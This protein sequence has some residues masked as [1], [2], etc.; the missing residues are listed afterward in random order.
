M[1]EANATS[2]A[3]F[4]AIRN[5]L[6]A[7]S[8][9]LPLGAGADG[10]DVDYGAGLS[11]LGAPTYNLADTSNPT[12]EAD[13]LP[14]SCAGS[15]Y[16]VGQANLGN[17]T[18]NGS[19]LTPFTS[20]AAAL[21]ATSPIPECIIVMPGEYVTPIFIENSYTEPLLVTGY[22]DVSRLNTKDVI[23]W[24]RGLYYN[25]GDPSEYFYPDNPAT[26][27]NEGVAYRRRAGLYFGDTSANVEFSGFTFVAARFFTDSEGINNTSSPQAVVMDGSTN[28]AVSN[29]QFG[30]I[31]INNVEYPGWNNINATPILIVN[32]AEGARIESNKF[33]DNSTNSLNFF[34]TLAVINS[35]AVDNPV[36]IIGNDISGNSATNQGQNEWSA[37]L[38]SEGSH[39]D[40]INN[41]IHDNTGETIIRIKSTNP[42]DDPLS[43][44]I[45][46]THTHRARIVGNVFLNN[47]TITGSAQKVAGALINGHYSPMIYIINNTMVNNTIPTASPFGQ[48]FSRGD[49]NSATP[50]G[51]IQPSVANGW[52]FWEIHNNLIYNNTYRLLV[53]DTF[54]GIASPSCDRIPNDVSSGSLL[55]AFNWNHTQG[56]NQANDP[57]GTFRNR[58]AQNNW[59]VSNQGTF[60]I[61]SGGEFGACSDAI[62]TNKNSPANPA[63]NNQNIVQADNQ[64]VDIWS[65]DDSLL[66][67][68]GDFQGILTQSEID[69]PLFVPSH[70][71]ADW[72]YYALADTLIDANNGLLNEYSDGI[73]AARSKWLTDTGGGDAGDLYMDNADVEVDIFATKRDLDVN[74]WEINWS[75]YGYDPLIAPPRGVSDTVNTA[76]YTLDIGA[77]EFSPLQFEIN[78]VGE[79]DYYDTDDVITVETIEYPAQT[80]G[81]LEDSG[82]VTFNFK[83][84]VTG[85][86]GKL[87]FTIFEHPANYGVQ[88]DDKF[89][90]TKG[91]VNQGIGFNEYF[92]YCPPR[93]FYTSTSNSSPDF[94]S[95]KIKVTDEAGA[96]A[97]GE[98]RFTIDPVDDPNLPSTPVIGDD[99]PS[100]TSFEVVT[101]LG[102]NPSVR[103]RPYTR[104]DNFFFSENDNSDFKSGAQL[105]VDYPFTYTI[106]D[107]D[108]L[109]DEILEGTYDDGFTGSLGGNPVI[110]L[111]LSESNTG[112]ATITYNITDARGNTSTGNKLIVRSVSIIPAEGLHDDTS[113]VWNYSDAANAKFYTERADHNS[114]NVPASG[115][116]KAL[117][118]VGA[119][120]NT[121]HTTETVGDT[122]TFR[123][124]GTGFTAFMRGVSGSTGTFALNIYD[125]DDIQLG[126]THLWSAL[127]GSDVVNEVAGVDTLECTTRAGFD[128]IDQYLLVSDLDEFTITCNG[129]D[130]RKHTVQIVNTGGETLSV[131]AF[132]IIND[133]NSFTNADPIP[134][135]FHDVDNGVLRNAF[136]DANW[137]ETGETFYSNGVAFRLVTPTDIEFTITRASGFAIG[138]SYRNSASNNFNICV[139]NK[140]NGTTG[141]CSKVEDNIGSTLNGIHIPFFGLNP[142][143]DYTVTLTNLTTGFIFDD[144]IVFDELLL[145]IA[146]LPLGKTPYSDLDISFGEPFGDDWKVSD[147]KQVIKD[148]RSPIGPF[149]AFQMD[150]VVDTIGITVDNVVPVPACTPSKKVVCPPPPPSGFAGL[151]VCVNR[152]NVA[153][154]NGTNYGNCIFIDTYDN[155]DSESNPFKYVNGINGDIETGTNI[156]NT[157]GIIVIPET[158]FNNGA[159]WGDYDD[160]VVEIFSLYPDSG[161]EFEAVALYSSTTGLGDGSYTVNSPGIN[162]LKYNHSANTYTQVSIDDGSGAFD[163]IELK[164]CIKEKKGVCQEEISLGTLMQTTDIGN[165]VLFKTQGTS[166]I[167]RFT[168]S[169]GTLARVCIIKDS[170][171]GSVTPATIAAEI[172]D[173]VQANGGCE[174]LDLNGSVVNSPRYIN[175]INNISHYVMIELLPSPTNATPAMNFDGVNIIG[176]NLDG[177]DTLTIGQVYETSYTNRKSENKFLYSGIWETKADTN[178][179]HL[180]TSYDETDGDAGASIVFKTSNGNVLNIIR[181][182]KTSTPEVCTG[183]GKKQVCTPGINGFSDITVCV[184]PEDNTADRHCSVHNNNGDATQAVLPI[185]LN[186]SFDSGIDYVVSITASSDGFAID[187]VEIL[188]TSANKMTVGIYQENSSLISYE[189]GQ[190]EILKNTSFE[191]TSLLNASSGQDWDWGISS[192][193][194]ASVISESPFI[195]SQSLRLDGDTNEGVESETFDIVQ[196]ISYTAIARVHAITGTVEM[197]SNI[198]GFEV[199]STQ[200][201]GKWELLRYSFVATTDQTVQLEF[202]ASVNNTSFQVDD[203]HVYKGGAWT[204]GFGGLNDGNIAFSKGH[205]SQAKFMFTGTGFTVKLASDT[206]SGETQVCYDNGSNENCFTYDDEQPLLVNLVCSSKEIDKG[207]CPTIIPPEA[208]MGHTV[209]NLPSDDY[210]VT[211]Q[212]MDNGLRTYALPPECSLKDYKKDRCPEPSTGNT[213]KLSASTVNIDYI[214]IYDDN[215]P[216]VLLEGTY[217]EDASFS[218]VPGMQ[219]YPSNEWEQITGASGFTNQSYYQVNDVQTAG[220]ILTLKVDNDP[221]PA[222]IIIDMH[223]VTE[224]ANQLLACTNDVEGAVTFNGTGY[225]L[226]S[227]S[228]V[229]TDK[230]T[231]Q[232]QLVF[233]ENNLPFLDGSGGDTIFSLGSLTKDSVTIDGYQVLYGDILTDGY[234][235]EII[236]ASENAGA[237]LQL[238]DDDDWSLINGEGFSGLNALKTAVNGATLDFTFEGTGVSILMKAPPPFQVCTSFKNGSCAKFSSTPVPNGFV[239][240]S[241]T[242]AVC[243][244]VCTFDTTTSNIASIDGAITLA[245]LPKGTYDL[246]LTSNITLGQEVVVDAIEIFGDLQE[247]GSLY[248]DAQLNI[249]GTPLL[250]FGPLWTATTNDITGKFL[251]NTNH[252]SSKLGAGVSFVVSGTTPTEAI[253]IYDGNPTTSSS[254]VEVCWATTAL[255]Q[256]CGP[257]NLND[258]VATTRVNA[259]APGNYSVSITNQAMGQPLVIDAIQVVEEGLMT[260]GIYQDNYNGFVFS[261]SYIPIVNA[262]AS[263]SSVMQLN[264]GESVTFTFEGIAFSALVVE[265]SPTF[266]VCVYQGAVGDGSCIADDVVDDTVTKTINTI[267]AVAYGGFHN[268]N[269][270]DN[271]EWTVVITNNHATPLFIDRID[272]LGNHN[273]LEITDSSIYEADEPQ[274]RYLPFGSWT[275]Q[276]SFKNGSPLNGT[277]HQTIIPGSIAYFEFNDDFGSG[278]VGI[279]YI[280]QYQDEFTP[281]PLCTKFKKDV[282]VKS[283][284]QETIPALAAANICYGEVGDPSATCLPSPVSNGV[285]PAPNTDSVVAYQFGSSTDPISPSCGDGCWGF[286]SYQR[287]AVTDSITPLDYIRLYDPEATLLA[288]VYQENH[289]NIMESEIP[290]T[291]TD[292]NANV[293]FYNVISGTVGES[294]FNFAFEGTGIS[295]RTF[296]GSNADEISLCVYEYVGALPNVGTALAGSTCL[297]TYDNVETTDGFV[298]RS[299]QGLN[300]DAQYMAFL[301]MDSDGSTVLG[302]D[303]VT[304]YNKQWFDES[305]LDDSTYLYELTGGN[306]YPIN[307]KTRNTDKFVQFLGDWQIVSEQVLVGY[308]DPKKQKGPIY[309]TE[310]HDRALESGATTLFR[311]DGANALGVD[312]ELGELGS[313]QIC[314]IPMTSS[315][316]FEVDIAEGATCQTIT[317]EG[318]TNA[319]FEFSDDLSP[320]VITIELLSNTWMSVYN[321]SMYDI[322]SGLGVGLYD[323][324]APGIKYDI[325]YEKLI[326]EK[327]EDTTI[328][329]TTI[330]SPISNTRA[331]LTQVCIKIKNGACSKYETVSEPHYSGDYSR[332]LIA[333]IGQGIQYVGTGS[334]ISLDEDTFYTATARVYI[335]PTTAGGVAMRLVSGTE[336]I[337]EIIGLDLS[338]TTRGAWQTIRADFYTEQ[339]YDQLLLQ[340]VATDGQATFFID[341]VLL[342]KGGLWTNAVPPIG[343][344]ICT[345]D[346]KPICV[347]GTIVFDTFGGD[348]YASTTP[349]ASIS[350]DFIGTGFELGLVGGNLFG[351]VE[352]CYSN[353]VGFANPSCFTYSQDDGVNPISVICTKEKKGVCLTSVTSL[354][355]TTNLI[356]RGIV[357]LDN[358]TWTVRIR[359]LDDGYNLSSPNETRIFGNEV[360]TKEKNGICQQSTVTTA[361][362]NA[363]IGLDYVYIFEDTDIVTVPSGS[364]NEDAQDGSNNDYLALYPED[365]WQSFSGSSAF[366]KKT[367]VAPT[368][369]SQASTHP[370][371]VALTQINVEPGD[372]DAAIVF[373]FGGSA[374][375][376]ADTVMICV[377]ETSGKMVWD[378][379]EFDLVDSD[380][381]MLFNGV[382]TLRQ[383]NITN[384]DIALLEVP[385]LHNVTITALTSGLFRIDDFQIFNG[386]ALEA[387]LHNESLPSKILSLSPGLLNSDDTC[388]LTNEWCSK[389]TKTVTQTV[390]TSFKKNTC[391][392]SVTQ[393]V[394]TSPYLGS[395]ALTSKS[396]AVANFVIRGT[397]FSLISDVSNN[398]L[399]FRVCYK[400]ESS[401]TS[402]PALDSSDELLALNGFDG[403][404][405]PVLISEGGILCENLTSDT[406]NWETVMDRPVSS[407]EQYGFSFYGLPL[408]IYEVQVMVTTPQDEISATE[409]FTLDAINVFSDFNTLSALQPGLSDDTNANISYEPSV[410]W[411]SNSTSNTYENTDSTTDHAG[412]I[413]QFKVAGNT[414]VLYQTVG[415]MSPDVQICLLIS[416][417]NIHCSVEAERQARLARQ[418]MSFTQEGDNVIEIVCIKFKKSNCTLMGPQITPEVAVFTPIVFYGL[419]DSTVHTVIMEN[420]VQGET[421]NIDALRVRE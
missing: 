282:C 98:V 418:V 176:G 143:F 129:L 202:A 107:I 330:G 409:S 17:T 43:T 2:A 347:P 50:T 42:T 131:D 141:L 217:N 164:Q 339:D 417:E 215:Q 20:I 87:T 68:N 167:P 267:S 121:V 29:S 154:T 188:D 250:T 165:A 239:S 125:D 199:Q 419:G 354:T 86:F 259:P 81:L 182:L 187:A 116:W 309:V 391:K 408:A 338:T 174:I 399:D 19:L 201:N 332:K 400:L 45:T 39:I 294:Y 225:D 162:Y 210:L 60:S 276:T 211:I 90:N 230:A 33:N 291:I 181:D 108:D 255:V 366:S 394:T 62:F 7:R 31:L 123:F 214:Q 142:D 324:S 203:V 336:T 127:A 348:Y 233:N 358:D 61:G 279:E 26:I 363:S 192:G 66:A 11:I 18:I 52:A 220:S 106:T 385:G 58:G 8:I 111:E 314:A 85:G 388:N 235:E 59:I 27:G 145:P 307:F 140:T 88:C 133:D 232:T 135:G 285:V 384:D 71:T 343:P 359:E 89:E 270:S 315:A 257:V 155:V 344:D 254:L 146:N 179:T 231:S 298:T 6:Q 378:G 329:W 157:G 48:L 236:G 248:D 5:Y 14:S 401:G 420:R 268:S 207:Q 283:I 222:T 32:E 64:P 310:E 137:L 286:I 197:R 326:D 97:I 240:I 185:S 349:G 269:G 35:G 304:V 169:A 153:D 360:C 249:N 136:N 180:G 244:G 75:T 342:T 74:N 280:R 380:N 306:S 47:T 253:V 100:G 95:F 117:R 412:A 96:V 256:T 334:G 67:R 305:D 265:N 226:E 407:G 105:F 24:L 383:V 51:S 353:E 44:N 274:I 156:V 99:A 158:L 93:N 209:A 224:N 395:A 246:T 22:N 364:Y 297:R 57:S 290:D 25:E 178:G 104:Y 184:A 190:T 118:K 403:I 175:G 128:S 352:V 30:K 76:E 345:T 301:K 148:T 337:S 365:S 372:E 242:S 308:E 402:F 172:Q 193:V 56:F 159:G 341:D 368:T 34:P 318:R 284:P 264:N 113:F 331:G 23:F 386:R 54:W 102:T 229:L 177:L 126:S 186:T 252:T 132:S 370:G 171:I 218:N 317:Q 247:L 374:S 350:F 168:E 375:G 273:E 144:L 390:C 302:L 124:V 101:T 189:N 9:D 213:S 379:T 41:S 271:E 13:I 78:C 266:H 241:M 328:Q 212:Q 361:F 421:F 243:G 228:C 198:S 16:Y 12:I 4:T 251:N 321:I 311:V 109:D 261:N 173:E 312:L 367:Y 406:D 151:A 36:T 381:C 376:M 163:T 300:H 340:L 3:T 219:L 414:L 356:G 369:G 398:G 82:I 316:D 323:Q 278:S 295:I 40:I 122:A 237:I 65:T 103:L 166:I 397:G 91:L 94:V 238:S 288:G 355:D 196:G 138:T 223:Q 139:E 115:D 84:V 208:N 281:E 10:F 63:Y 191:N 320:H 234:Y 70:T 413:S 77:F 313:I 362:V 221:D 277:S 415:D 346:K 55:Y 46:A 112:E 69:D 333:N 83:P 258:G 204:F 120:N 161:F 149:I 299:L 325:A 392:K 396:G 245:G 382:S 194:S 335:D 327:M 170:L 357:G 114:T 296:E 21:N 38:Y 150:N 275:E 49:A 389:K 216:P 263:N 272:V 405:L 73:D 28:T 183:S 293:G 79:C 319:S 195:G 37:I 287:D 119:I 160:N 72:Q 152:G 322:L 134:P 1:N 292:S 110:A 371:P 289:P 15:T 373:Q 410:F 351:D 53:G 393:T 404:G 377:D 200:F 227:S 262:N 130:P 205:G 411:E 260:E 387:G 303:Q 206:A 416:N 92:D 80:D 147:N